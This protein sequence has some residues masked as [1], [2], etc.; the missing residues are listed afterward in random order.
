VIAFLKRA[1]LALLVRLL[2]HDLEETETAGAL[3]AERDAA[4]AAPRSREETA[5]ELGEDRF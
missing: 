2:R 5:K 4:A 3:E 1:A